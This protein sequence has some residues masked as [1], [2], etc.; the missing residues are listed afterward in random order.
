MPPVS[1]VKNKTKKENAAVNA[2][3]AVNNDETPE[4]PDRLKTSVLDFLRQEGGEAFRAREVLGP[5]LDH[6]DWLTGMCGVLWKRVEHN[7]HDQNL[8]ADLGYMSRLIEE[9]DFEDASERSEWE[10]RHQGIIKSQR[11]KLE[12]HQLQQSRLSQP[13]ARAQAINSYKD[14]SSAS[15]KVSK[16]RKKR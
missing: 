15:P 14:R 3:P 9:C 5:E 12:D 11:D 10:G 6:S 1:R 2:E 13:R 4:M 7:P 8:L 16:G